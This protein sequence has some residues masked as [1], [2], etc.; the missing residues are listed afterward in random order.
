[1]ANAMS[2]RRASAARRRLG[3]VTWLLI[4]IL[5]A[6]LAAGLLRAE[7][8]AR[9]YFAHAHGGA[10]TVEN[11]EVAGVIPLF[12][13]FWG[14]AINGEVREPQM[15]TGRGYVSAMLLVVEP[16]TG[17]VFVFGAG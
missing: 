6:W 16:F 1:M 17:T 10:A 3:R 14:V 7:P 12:P 15:T 5:A 13:P 8:V 11:V 4:L 9:D 2:A